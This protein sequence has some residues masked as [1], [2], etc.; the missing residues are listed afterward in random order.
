MFRISRG[1]QCCGAIEDMVFFRCCVRFDRIAIYEIVCHYRW[2]FHCKWPRLTRW[3]H[4]HGWQKWF[5]RWKHCWSTCRLN[6]TF[7]M[8]NSPLLNWCATVGCE[9]STGHRC[10]FNNERIPLFWMLWL[11]HM[12]DSTSIMNPIS[13]N[14]NGVVGLYTGSTWHL[15]GGTHSSV[16]L[17]CHSWSRGLKGSLRWIREWMVHRNECRCWPE[18]RDSTPIHNP[19]SVFHIDHVRKLVC[20]SW[21]DEWTTQRGQLKWTEWFEEMN[22]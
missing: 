15:G 16:E 19:W 7:W 22:D 9:N 5:V 12:L 13:V 14:V 3:S 4:C 11:V 20:L 2:R 21:S 10:E 17:L 18:Y 8:V 6:S 1:F